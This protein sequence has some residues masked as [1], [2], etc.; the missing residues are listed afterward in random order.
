MTYEQALKMINSTD[1]YHK[2]QFG[3]LSKWKIVPGN[4][5]DYINCLND[6]Y[7][8]KV[9]INNENIVNY[10][11]D[12]DFAIMSFICKYLPEEVTKC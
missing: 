3:F 4:T 2:N 5:E 9:L 1:V 12:N 10:S 7:K 11:S 6:L 8:N